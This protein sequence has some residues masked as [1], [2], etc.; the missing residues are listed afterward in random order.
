MNLANIP[1]GPR[2]C[3]YRLSPGSGALVSS[4]SASVTTFITFPLP[5][6]YEQLG[7][8]SP[9]KVETT[10]HLIG[11]SPQQRRNPGFRTASWLTR[12]IGL[13]YL[14]G[15]LCH[16]IQAMPVA[17]SRAQGSRAPIP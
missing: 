17:P 9:D 8:V 13:V 1:I 2:Y 16:A 12:E 4:L 10:S 14:P 15:G 3:R 7:L 11:F 5:L 6:P